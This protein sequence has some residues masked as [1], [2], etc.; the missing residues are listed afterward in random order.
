[1]TDLSNTLLAAIDVGS[2]AI[3]MDI[4]EVRPD[5]QIHILDSLKK[6][7]Q[8]GRGAFMEGHLSEESIRAACDAMK[9][10]KKVMETYGVV[11]YRAVATS[12]VRE[13]SNSETFLNRVLMSTGLDLEII[14]GPEENRLT[15]SAVQESLRNGPELKTGKSLLVE[16]GGGST[17]VTLLSGTEPVQSG[18]FPWVPFVSV[19]VWTP[20]QES[21]IRKCGCL[22]AR[23]PASF[24]T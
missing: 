10:F 20:H 1:M 9:D 5:G 8:L 12:A 14:D 23:S 21:T 17:D 15:Y 7:V 2:S 6:G 16:V 11:R 24:P 19:R 13:S 22:N 18:T 3:R 4:A